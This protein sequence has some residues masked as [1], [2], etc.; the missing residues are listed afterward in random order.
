[1]FTKSRVLFIALPC[2]MAVALL[3]VLFGLRDQNAPPDLF[4]QKLDVRLELRDGETG[5]V[6]TYY[7]DGITRKHSI[8]DSDDGK[9]SQFWYREDDTLK[10]A[11]TYGV[12][13]D[14][15]RPLLRR[16][17]IDTDGKTFVLDEE[18]Q[19]DGTIARRLVL[20]DPDTS[21]E[22]LFFEGLSAVLRQET[23]IS[24]ANDA[25]TW[26][27]VEQ[28]EYRADGSKVT[29]TQVEDEV[30]TTRIFDQDERL[31]RIKVHTPKKWTYTETDYR[32]EDGSVSRKLVQDND[33][34]TITFIRS[35]GSKEESWEWFGPAGKSGVHINYFNDSE[36]RTFHQWWSFIDEELRLN[37]ADVYDLKIDSIARSYYV[38]AYD[39]RGPVGAIE[40]ERIYHT[41][42]GNNGHHSINN[43]RHDGTLSSHTEYSSGS[44]I[45]L[46]E[47]HS[48]EENIR[49]TDANQRWFSHR[50]LEEWPTQVVPYTPAE[51]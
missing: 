42:K 21:V 32:S 35:N 12:E 11:V 34:T 3:F 48:A 38:N 50:E 33:S 20:K 45:I 19:A 10:E 36:E 47:E 5:R 46:Q 27:L 23:T 26:K 29:H 43:Y 17:R 24:R 40:I 15:K 49:M 28:F 22:S 13:V 39:E 6:V 9:Q 30:K 14:G 8:A 44:D 18:Y 1:M 37:S 7:P 16:A 31:V 4:Q 2:L 25:R 51:D 41:D